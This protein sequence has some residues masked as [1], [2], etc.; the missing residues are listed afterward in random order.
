MAPVSVLVE[1][2]PRQPL[3]TAGAVTIGVGLVA[4]VATVAWAADMG[5]TGEPGTMGLGLFGFIVIWTVMMAA[6]M[7]P[8]IAPLVTLYARTVRDHRTARLTSF[9]CGFVLA[10]A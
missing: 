1:A 6:M 3:S 9:G 2:P 4:W 7:L 5:M 10:W 8:A